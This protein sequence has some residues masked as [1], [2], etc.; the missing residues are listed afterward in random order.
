[1]RFSSILHG[2]PCLDEIPLTPESSGKGEMLFSSF[3]RKSDDHFS[4]Q[5]LMQKVLLTDLKDQL[6]LSSRR[7]DRTEGLIR[8][9]QENGYTSARVVEERGI[10]APGS[11][12]DIFRPMK[13]PEAR[14]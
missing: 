10:M 7:G 2:R 13:N 5:A 6:F 8:Y 9:F 3:M 4:V 14:V 11:D 1:V 12:L